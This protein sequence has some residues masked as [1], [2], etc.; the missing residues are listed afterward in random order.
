MGGK[1]GKSPAPA[2]TVVNNSNPAMDMYLAQQANQ[3][4]RDLQQSSN[5][6]QLMRSPPPIQE[7]AVDPGL[8]EP[9]QQEQG[10]YDPNA[11]LATLLDALRKG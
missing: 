11:Q 5:N 2:P 3:N 7:P 6:A 1:G 4:Q 9:I 8:S 10:G